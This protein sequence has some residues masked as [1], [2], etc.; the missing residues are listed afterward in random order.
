MDYFQYFDSKFL[1][2]D[3]LMYM[4]PSKYKLVGRTLNRKL[5]KCLDASF[6]LTFEQISSTSMTAVNKKQYLQRRHTRVHCHCFRNIEL[7][8]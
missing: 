8:I 4:L 7:F 1:I 2:F 6:S 5:F 3:H